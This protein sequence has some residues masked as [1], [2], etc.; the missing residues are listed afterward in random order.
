[1]TAAVA[2]ARLD[3]VRRPVPTARP[4]RR[5]STLGSCRYARPVAFVGQRGNESPDSSDPS[6]PLPSAGPPT[7]Y[8]PLPVGV[9]PFMQR[10]SKRTRLLIA[11]GAT[12]A[13]GAACTYTFLVDPNTSSAYPQCP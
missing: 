8:G 2:G 3:R 4:P 10:S 5:R 12:L 1:R 6:S 9:E 13:I 11:G 7:G